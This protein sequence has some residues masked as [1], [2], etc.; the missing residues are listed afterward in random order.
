MTAGAQ[1]FT[2]DAARAEPE[3]QAGAYPGGERH[4]P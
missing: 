2:S 4:S 3:P 1:R